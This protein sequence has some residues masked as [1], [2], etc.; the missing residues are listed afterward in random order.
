MLKK[1]FLL[2][3]LCAFVSNVLAKRNKHLSHH[4]HKHSKQQTKKKIKITKLEY[5]KLSSY[6]TSEGLTAS[7][8]STAPKN[9][10]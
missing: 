3:C 4:R 5:N 2:I 10:S 8:K 1:Y 6:N 9:N 7:S